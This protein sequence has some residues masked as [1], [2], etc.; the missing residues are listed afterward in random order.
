MAAV[1]GI[2]FTDLV[3]LPKW[4]EAGAVPYGIPPLALLAIQAP[5]MGFLETKRLEGFLATGKSGFLDSFPFDPLNQMSPT[6]ELN[7]IKNGRLAMFSMLGFFVQAIVTG[8]VRRASCGRCLRFV[9]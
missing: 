3:G 6:K 4:Y 8:E 5:I 7:E 2:L 1:A 9:R